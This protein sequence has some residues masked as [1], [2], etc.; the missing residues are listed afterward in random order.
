MCSK[1]EDG[2]SVKPL[3]EQGILVKLQSMF[4]IF[5][6]FITDY[7]WIGNLNL[8]SRSLVCVPSCLFEIH[9][10]IT[11]EPLKT[12]KEPDY[13]K[14]EGAKRERVG[15]QEPSWFDSQD[16]VVLKANPEVTQR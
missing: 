11:P 1:S 6:C 9:L 14:D 12:V 8:S 16:L 15:R 5:N 2:V 4:L 7:L 13:P 3:V 10:G